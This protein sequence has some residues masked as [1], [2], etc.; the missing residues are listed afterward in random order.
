MSRSV[1]IPSDAVQVAYLND[2]FDE[3]WEWDDFIWEIQEAL[4]RRFPSLSNDSGWLGR[5]DRIVLS[6][7]L[8]QVTIS[9]YCGIVSVALVPREFESYYSDQASLEA[10]SKVWCQRIKF[11]ERINEDFASRALRR[12]GTFSN[13]EAILEYVLTNS[14]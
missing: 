12:I 14:N 8:A 5:E 7:K 10:L 13:G 11:T 9:E 4:K 6:N 3:E 2:H 1:S